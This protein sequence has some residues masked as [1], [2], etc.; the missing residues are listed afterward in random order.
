MI[1]KDG[2][3]YTGDFVDG[4]F[5]G[6]GRYI[7]NKDAKSDFYEGEFKVNDANG[8]GEKRFKSGTHYKG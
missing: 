3:V 6:K 5:H 4:K 2:D 1:Y 8:Q 7:W